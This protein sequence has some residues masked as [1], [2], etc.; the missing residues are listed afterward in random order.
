MDSRLP[1]LR[2]STLLLPLCFQLLGSAQQPQD[3]QRA[4]STEDFPDSWHCP[5]CGGLMKVIRKAQRCRNST[6]FSTTAGRCSLQLENSAFFGALRTAVPMS[7]DRSILRASSPTVF[8]TLCGS[9]HFLRATCHVSWSA[10]QSR[11][12][13]IPFFPTIEFA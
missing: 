12:R 11:H 6:S 5:K 9:S 13:L 8:A 1:S 4:S 7:P 3:E 10:A 2:P